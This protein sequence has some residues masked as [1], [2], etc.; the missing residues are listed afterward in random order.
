M[1]CRRS[2]LI[3]K[4]SRQVTALLIRI[5]GLLLATTGAQVFLGGLKNFFGL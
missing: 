1:V 5:G 3:A 4:L 2:G